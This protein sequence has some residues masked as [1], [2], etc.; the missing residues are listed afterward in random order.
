[1][2]ALIFWRSHLGSVG[3]DLLHQLP[4]RTVGEPFAAYVSGEYT[5]VSRMTDVH[6]KIL[7]KS[8]GTHLQPIFLEKSP[9]IEDDQCTP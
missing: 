5:Q 1:M 9:G 7:E 2:Y 4:A 6:P 3:D 8:V